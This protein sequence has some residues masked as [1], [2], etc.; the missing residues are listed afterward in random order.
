MHAAFLNDYR[1]SPSP[2]VLA[3]VLFVLLQLRRRGRKAER[4][5]PAIPDISLA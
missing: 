3:E 5:N 4:D 2:S 1:Y